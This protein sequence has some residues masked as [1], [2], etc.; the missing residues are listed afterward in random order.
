MLNVAY[1]ADDPQ[2]AAEIARAYASAY[3]SD[4]LNANFDA[5]QRATVWLQQRLGDLKE[6]A[7]KASMAAARYKANNGLTLARGQLV[8]EQQLSDLNTQL[9]KA[10]ADLASASARYQAV[11][12]DRRRGAEGCREER[13]RLLLLSDMTTD[14]SVLS[15]LKSQYLSVSNRADAVEARFGKDHPQ[16]VSLR[17]QQQEL[18][19]QIYQELRQLTT[20]YK[21]E[22]DVAKSR[23]DSLQTSIAEADR[24]DVRMPTSRSCT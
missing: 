22:Y 9:I 5:T 7:Q 3:L 15:K 19:D 2:L 18:A 1:T 16:V 6:N 14:N 24:Q 13:H 21:N 4:Q 10:Q 11:Q 23:V 8:S 20:S 17:K 12:V